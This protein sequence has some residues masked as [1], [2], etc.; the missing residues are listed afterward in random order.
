[1]KKLNRSVI[2]TDQTIHRDEDYTLLY[3]ESDV[4]IYV[5]IDE[6]KF[7]NHET[8]GNFIYTLNKPIPS[9]T[10]ALAVVSGVLFIYPAYLYAREYFFDLTVFTRGG[11]SSWSRLVPTTKGLPALWIPT[12]LRE[13]FIEFLNE[14]GG[15]IYEE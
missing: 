9:D 15:N 2:V 6:N 11:F 5:R 7:V 12:C 3:E 4:D 14:A 8:G 13:S 1:M 10:I